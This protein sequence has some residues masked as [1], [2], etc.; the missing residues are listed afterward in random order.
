MTEEI[1]VNHRAHE[2]RVAI[3]QQGVV[4][5]L[6][7]ERA[8]SRGLVG[9][10]YLGRVS[11][12]LPGMQSAFIDIGLERAAFLHVADLWQSRHSH[13]PTGA[14]QPIEKL[15]FEGQ[16]LLVQVIKDP[17]GTK[18]ARLSTQVSIA[19]RLLVYL[20]HEPHI[21]V[22]QRIGD[23]QGREALRTRMQALV[24][25]DE[26]G[27]F[28]VRTLAEDANSDELAA[29][30]AYLRRRWQQI[31]DGSRTYAAPSLIYQELALTQRVLRDLAGEAT[32][33]VIV[34]SREA[35][36][37][38]QEFA[39]AWMPTMTRRLRLHASERPVF[40]LHGIEQEIERALLRRVDLKSGGYLVI[41]QTEA[42]TTIDVNTGSFVGGR[43]FEDTVFRTNL[44][45]AHAIARQLR[46][47]NL[48]GIVVVDLI[49]M[50]D[51]AHRDA[52]LAELRKAAQRDRTRIGIN[53]FTS[54]GL[55]EITRKRT[56]E[57]LARVLCEP[58]PICS[59]TGQIKTARTLCYEILRE[60]QREAGQF[61]PREF[62]LVAAQSIVDLFLEEEAQL[63]AA[64]CDAI[65]RQISLMVETTYAQEHYDIVLL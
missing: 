62:R 34:D 46:L 35:L 16:P 59:G 33:S 8:A 65:G 7:I 41:D 21:G 10:L 11:R 56:R 4:Q 18:G 27:G 58:C 60:I 15:L 55:V 29:D 24:P 1:L 30:I 28:I 25:T 32:S 12:V 22:S 37:Q 36:A 48:G 64:L 49:D 50:R 31:L 19:G 26:K 20:P 40:E 17:L 13:A 44:E 45:A 51:S 9:N 53:G 42:M 39:S 3:V 6:L 54:L 47:R 2:T 52:V 63:L 61:N 14:Q 57:S 23:E 38:M 43:N 5:E